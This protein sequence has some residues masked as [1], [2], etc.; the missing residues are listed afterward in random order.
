MV[1]NADK[2]ST[3]IS[4]NNNPLF[5]HIVCKIVQA[6]VI[7]HDE[8]FQALAVKGDVLLQ[9]LFLDLGFDGIVR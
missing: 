8:I 3:W 2:K 7:T 5:S 1:E 6:L 4:F 9:N